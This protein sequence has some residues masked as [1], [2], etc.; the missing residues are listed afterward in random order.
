MNA[1]SVVRKTG[2]LTGGTGGKTPPPVFGPHKL[3]GDWGNPEISPSMT[4][5]LT[6]G[7]PQRQS[8]VGDLRRVLRVASLGI[9]S[10]RSSLSLEHKKN[11][12]TSEASTVVMGASAQ[13]RLEDFILRSTGRR[14]ACESPINW[15]APMNQQLNPRFQ[16]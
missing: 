9:E 6:R 1:P 15:T 12:I 16:E 3:T 5:G 2:G 8:P 7:T 13:R 14:A 11:P 10:P 4:G